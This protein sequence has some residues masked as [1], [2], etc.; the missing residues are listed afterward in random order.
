MIARFNGEEISS[1]VIE[2]TL[3]RVWRE[4]GSLVFEQTTL[5]EVLRGE[6]LLQACAPPPRPIRPRTSG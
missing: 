3:N 6:I 5:E 4:N 1:T 2:Q